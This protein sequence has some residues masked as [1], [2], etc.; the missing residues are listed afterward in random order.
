MGPAVPEHAALQKNPRTTSPILYIATWHLSARWAGEHGCMLWVA[1]LLLAHLLPS[2]RIAGASGI[3]PCYM[4][5]M[6]KKHLVRVPL[7][8]VPAGKLQGMLLALSPGVEGSIR[9]PGTPVRDAAL[10][11]VT[12]QWG[13]Q[14]LAKYLHKH[15]L[16][17]RT[18]KW[19]PGRSGASENQSFSQSQDKLFPH[20]QANQAPIYI[21]GETLD[22]M[23]CSWRG[24]VTKFTPA[25]AL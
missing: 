14:P 18:D 2:C 8:K 16:C 22:N 21:T 15:V 7:C 6:C 3:L 11:Q 4:F 25:F 10:L 20:I 13:R 5:Y 19:V 17:R 12:A 1:A 23:P 9:L 24:K